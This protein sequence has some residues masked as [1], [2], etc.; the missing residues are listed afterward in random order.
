MEKVLNV[1]LTHQPPACVE[2][3]LEWWRQ[4]VDPAD[5]LIAHGGRREDFEQVSHFLKIFCDD[6]RLH[7]VDHQREFQSYTGLFRAISQWLAGRAYTHVSFCEYDHL[8]LVADF[9]ARQLVRLESESADV[10]GCHVRRVDGTNHP[11]YLYHRSNPEFHRFWAKITRRDDPSVVLSMFGSGSFWTREAFDAVAAAEEPFRVYLEIH[12]PTLAHHLGFRVRDLPDQNPFVQVFRD[13][14]H[15]LDAARRGG[16][17]AVHPVKGRWLAPESAVPAG[18]CVNSIPRK[19]LWLPA[20]PSAGS[21]SML[22]HWRDLDHAFHAKG[23]D[24]MQ[25][26]CPLGSPPGIA[27]PAGRPRRAWDKYVAYPL[28]VGLAGQVDVVHVLDHSFAHLLRFAPHGSRRIV[29]VHDLAPLE[30]GTL[31]NT[32]LERFRRTLTWLNRADL[33]LAVSHATASALRAFLTTAPRIAVLPMGVDTEQFS[34]KRQLPATVK[35]PAIPRVLSIG[36]TFPRKNLAALPA[37][38]ERVTRA[39]GPVALLRIGQPLPDEL[40][41]KIGNV[42]KTENVIEFGVTPDEQVVAAYQAADALIF[43]SIL[44]G[45]G[46]P[47]AEAMAAGCPVV[48]SNASSLPEVGGDAA[49]YFDPADADAG[50]QHLIALVRDPAL[51]AE[52]IARGRRR[53]AELSWKRHAEKLRDYYRE[54][55]RLAGA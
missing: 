6:P 8:P 9:N 3:M 7:T 42:V 53:A 30:D 36:S 45:F 29:T 28:R 31:S 37:I 47:L 48:S 51:R 55:A 32:Q 15:E 44:E 5:L 26:V 16:A 49:L 50:A 27:P 4:F 2:A 46:L 1:V 23:G 40:R 11:H 39:L 17:W 12:L 19:V 10:I 41:Q 20:H 34:A 22:R 14:R 35:L 25:I 13:L 54:E 33:L 24:S 38:L 52:M 21:L 18:R 43:P